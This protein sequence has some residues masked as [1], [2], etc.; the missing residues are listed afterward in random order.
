MMTS[1]A[2]EIGEFLKENC[3]LKVLNMDDNPIGDVGLSQIMDGLQ[4]NTSLTEL[5]VARCGLSAKG[6]TVYCAF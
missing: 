5:S 3:I 6:T 4:V 2:R 1:G